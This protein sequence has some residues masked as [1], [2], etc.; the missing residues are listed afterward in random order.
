M[1][2]GYNIKKGAFGDE[3]LGDE[4]FNDLDLH[5]EV[6]SFDSVEFVELL[7]DVKTALVNNIIAVPFDFFLGGRPHE[8]R[9]GADVRERDDGGDDFGD[10]AGSEGFGG[11]EEGRVPVLALDNE[12]LDLFEEAVRDGRVRAQ[13]HGGAEALEKTGGAVVLDNI[14]DDRAPWFRRLRVGRLLP[15][16]YHAQRQR[17]ALAHHARERAD[18]EFRGRGQTHR[19]ERDL[20]P[21]DEVVLD[22][23]AQARV[24]VKVNVPVQALIDQVGG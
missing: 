5:A 7:E 16:R 14:A 17:H 23:L 22:V 1:G 15:R 9:F 24:N 21:L 19:S 2:R 18:G 4:R 20:A 10:R 6:P 12:L 3:G 8:A 11:G 13:D